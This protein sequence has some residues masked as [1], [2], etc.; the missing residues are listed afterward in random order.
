MRRVP[1]PASLHGVSDANTADASRFS[2]HV[3]TSLLIACHAAPFSAATRCGDTCPVRRRATAGR[4]VRGTATAM[5]HRTG[6][7]LPKR[8]AAPSLV[9]A[10]GSVRAQR[11]HAYARGGHWR[12][13]TAWCGGRWRAGSGAP[14]FGS[15]PCREAWRNGG[16]STRRR[17]D[18]NEPAASCLPPGS[19]HGYLNGGG[20]RS[21]GGGDVPSWELA[22]PRCVRLQSRMQCTRNLGIVGHLLGHPFT[23]KLAAT[24][25]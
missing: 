22:P 19:S 15:G 10:A 1:P 12:V 24:V 14:C 25:K 18:W 6:G 20:R 4:G 13:V 3:R 7:C 5:G 9:R 8:R 2:V 11:R 17:G 21:A 16:E 23:A